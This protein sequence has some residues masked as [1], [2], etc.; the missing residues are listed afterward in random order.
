M[1]ERVEMTGDEV[2]DIAIRRM[3][4]VLRHIEKRCKCR[5]EISC[6]KN[7]RDELRFSIGVMEQCLSKEP[8]AP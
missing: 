5:S 3:G 8:P 2:A 6:R 4:W 1:G 7:A